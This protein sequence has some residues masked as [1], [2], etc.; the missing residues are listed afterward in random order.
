M[1]YPD[2]P[3]SASHVIV[4]WFLPTASRTLDPTEVSTE[5]FTR[6][7]QEKNGWITPDII[8]TTIVGGISHDPI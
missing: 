2:L 8:S 6:N 4:G 7:I 1:L 5:R 3:I